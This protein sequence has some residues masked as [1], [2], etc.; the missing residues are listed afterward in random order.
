MW[1]K[2]GFL[3]ILCQHVCCK[4]GINNKETKSLIKV[5]LVKSPVFEL[6]ARKES[7]NN[8]RNLSDSGEKNEVYLLLSQFLKSDLKCVRLA[9]Y[10]NHGW[11]IHAKRYPFLGISHLS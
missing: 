5:E 8:K 6:A 2:L 10:F 7:A 11:S 9:V 4:N 3:T 1:I